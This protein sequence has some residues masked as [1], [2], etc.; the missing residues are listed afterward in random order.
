ML[1]PTGML[2]GATGIQEIWYRAKNLCIIDT[3]AMH[4]LFREVNRIP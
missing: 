2:A 1:I 3:S 4:S